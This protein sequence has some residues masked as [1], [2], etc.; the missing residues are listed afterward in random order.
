MNTEHKLDNH[1]AKIDD[2]VVATLYRRLVDYVARKLPESEINFNSEYTYFKYNGK[3]FLRFFA[4][5]SKMAIDVFGDYYQYPKTKTIKRGS[6]FKTGEINFHI[7]STS[8]FKEITK[9][10]DCSYNLQISKENKNKSDKIIFFNIGW[11]KYYQGLSSD[12]D[13]DIKFGGAFVDKNSFGHEIY[14]F[15]PHSGKLYGYVQP[16]YKKSHEMG[17]ININRLSGVRSNKKIKDVLVV[18][19]AKSPITESR[20]IVGWYKNATVYRNYQ[21]PPPNSNRIYNGEKIGYYTEANLADC[22]LLKDEQRENSNILIPAGKGQ[23]GMGRSNVWYADKETNKP[24]VK[25]VL[26]F[27][28]NYSGEKETDLEYQE[29]ILKAKPLKLPS[30]PIS[31]PARSG[32]INKQWKKDASIA[33]GVLNKYKFKCEVDKKHITFISKS[34]KNN[35]VEAHHLIPMSAQDD[36]YYSLD[37][38]GNIISLCPICHRL[39][40]F[41]TKS[42]KQKI[43][44]FLFKK[45]I[46]EIKAH[47][48]EITYEKL[49]S[50]Y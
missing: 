25:S 11:M 20:R 22:R 2:E 48:L 34:T 27:I 45:R 40:H 46:D 13:D 28:N 12:F 44:Q 10:I 17:T 37:V 39:V 15:Q 47:G 14:N 42:K 18:F 7:Y 26:K 1:I 43:L 36:F 41:A 23:K 31:R 32:G 33:K 6:K 49:T 9:I 16:V 21:E 8:S 3:R 35:Y 4:Q 38:P 19:V 5:K 24:L 30:G 50:Y 29:R